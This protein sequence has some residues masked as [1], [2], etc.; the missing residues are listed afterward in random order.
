MNES[1][2]AWESMTPEEKKAGAVPQ[3]KANAGFVS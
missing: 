2:T 3:T 1:Q